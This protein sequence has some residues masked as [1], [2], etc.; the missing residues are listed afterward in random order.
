MPSGP[1]DVSGYPRLSAELSGRGWP[2]DEL[3]ALAG[4]NVLRV[5]RSADDT[6]AVS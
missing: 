4:G 2:G 3:A 6:A 1:A 5:L